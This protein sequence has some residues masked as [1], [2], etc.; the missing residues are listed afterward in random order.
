MTAVTMDTL[1]FFENL[2]NAEMQAE[3]AK[4]LTQEIKEIQEQNIDQFIAKRDFEASKEVVKSL[5]V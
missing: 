4:V 2:Q 1:R 3:I 5:S